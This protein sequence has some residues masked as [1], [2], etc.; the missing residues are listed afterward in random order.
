[1]AELCHNL[2]RDNIALRQQL[3]AT[4]QDNKLLTSRLD[5]AKIRLQSLLQTLPEDD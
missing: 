1:V 5:A 2:R 3:L 4:Q